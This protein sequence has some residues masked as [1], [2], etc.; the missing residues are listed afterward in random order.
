MRIIGLSCRWRRSNAEE[1]PPT[2]VC[3][4][5]VLESPRSPPDD[6]SVIGAPHQP[7]N[8]PAFPLDLA[9]HLLDSRT[10]QPCRLE[11]EEI[12]HGPSRLAGVAVAI[13]LIPVGLRAQTTLTIEAPSID[14]RESATVTAPIIGHV[15]RGS[16]LHVTREDGDWVMVAW[17]ESAGGGYKLIE[18]WISC[19]HGRS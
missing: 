4:I 1:H 8:A 3:P 11:T 16:V 12:V 5:T 10:A 18:D 6:A 7:E 19:H 14:V 17:P 15:H 2:C 13:F 9:A